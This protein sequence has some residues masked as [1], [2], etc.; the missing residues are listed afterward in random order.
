[1]PRSVVAPA[2]GA[3]HR[4]A[5]ARRRGPRRAAAERRGQGG[6]DRR[7]RRGGRDARPRPARSPPPTTRVL[8]RIES[9]GLDANV[10]V[11]LTGLGLELGAETSPREPRGA[12]RR[13]GARAATSCGS[14]WRT[15]RRP[16][17]R[18]RL[19]RELRAAGYDNVGV[20]LQA[21]LR[22]TLADV[23]GLDERPALQGHLRR[24]ARGRLP[25][26]RRDP[27]Q[28]PRGARRA[29]RPG[30][31]RRD[32]DARRGADRRGARAGS[33]SRGLAHDQFEFQMLLGV[34]T[35]RGDELVRAGHRLRVYVP[36]GTHWY[37]YSL[38]RLQEN[39]KIA[40]Y[41]A[42]DTLRR[43]S[44]GCLAA[45]GG[46]SARGCR[47]GIRRR[48]LRL[49]RRL[50]EQAHRA[51]RE[52]LR[53]LL[54]RHPGTDRDVEDLRHAAQRQAPAGAST[55]SSRSTWP[56]S[57]SSVRRAVAA[58][59][60]RGDRDGAAAQRSTKTSAT[61]RIPRSLIERQYA[62]PPEQ[63]LG[64]LRREQEA[65]V[66]DEHVAADHLGVRASRG[67]RPPPRR[68]RARRAGRRGWRGR[69][70]ASR[71]CSG[72]GRA[73]RSRR[74]RPRRRSRGSRAARARP[75]GSGRAPR[76]PP[77]RRRSASSSASTR[78]EP[79]EEMPTIEEPAGICGAA[80]F[81]SASSAR[82]FAPSVQ[83][84]CFSVGVERVDARR[85][86]RR[87][88]R[89]RRAARAPPP[90]RARGSEVMLPAHEHRLGSRCAE[91]R[92]PSPRRP[93]RCAGS[94]S[95]RGSRRR[96]RSAA[97]S[98]ARSRASRP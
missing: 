2:L 18:S 77:S 35:A 70:R 63:P 68:P 79:S 23:P 30:H 56:S 83:S 89:A 42:A 93:C 98:R 39:P 51:V 66:D 54:R 36:F 72:S 75:R 47:C 26:S 41:V 31:L 45:A 34:R 62:R 38:R 12:R 82:A 1:M 7:P 6:D 55:R 33:A 44:P 50:V 87:C 46:S 95:R 84:Q 52:L 16:T 15:R 73:R 20:V 61:R 22:R 43:L 32:R 85:R 13:R 40:G 4:R 19:Y 9:E 11:K 53:G 5:D 59:V 74:R 37:E 71:P 65:A 86:R 96:A 80:A 10:S 60:D 29:A 58:P 8:E 90:R 57:V 81:A 94:R 24:A 91:L 14:T 28:L 76:A 49:G 3:L 64:L 69:R 92:R 97:R 67:T 21:Y 88:G 17:R 25:R 78:C 27:G 48:R